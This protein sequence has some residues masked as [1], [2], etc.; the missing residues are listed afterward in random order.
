VKAG[1]RLL[2]TYPESG[3]RQSVI[4]RR[5]PV[6]LRVELQTSQFATKTLWSNL[7][8]PGTENLTFRCMMESDL[9]VDRELSGKNEPLALSGVYSTGM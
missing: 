3:N 7:K 8:V 2:A 6:R 9:F 4:A 1:K 5:M